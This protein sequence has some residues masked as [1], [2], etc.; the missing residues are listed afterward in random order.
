MTGRGK[1]LSEFSTGELCVFISIS[2]T[3]LV[4][5]CF[6]CF[7]SGLGAAE[8]LLFIAVGAFAGLNCVGAALEFAARKT[9][10]RE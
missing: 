9:R 8:R 10:R 1:P 2:L 5:S 7:K 6:G 4:A 3:T